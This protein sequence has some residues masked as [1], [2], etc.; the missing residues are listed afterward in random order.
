N[1]STA[2]YIALVNGAAN[3][4]SLTVLLKYRRNP[5]MVPDLFVAMNWISSLIGVILLIYAYTVK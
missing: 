2:A 3:L 4:W 1:H 5:E